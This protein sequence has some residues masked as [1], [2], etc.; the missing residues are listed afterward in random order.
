MCE[1]TT[2]AGKGQWGKPKRTTT[3][4]S[5]STVRTGVWGAGWGNERTG[6]QATGNNEQ[7]GSGGAWQRTGAVLCG[8]PARGNSRRN[9]ECAQKRPGVKVG[10]VNEGMVMRN[11]SGKKMPRGCAAWRTTKP[12]SVVS[13]KMCTHAQTAR[14]PRRVVRR[15][16]VKTAMRQ[17]HA[18]EGQ[19]PQRECMW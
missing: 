3:F 14:E 12:A 4:K 13:A 10:S 18:R 17:N 5:G 16:C 15:A 8:K 7:E 6:S 1:G 19:N 11:G 9:W 2:T